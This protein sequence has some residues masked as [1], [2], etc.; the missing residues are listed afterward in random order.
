[1]PARPLEPLQVS[2]QSW[3]NFHADTT[4]ADEANDGE[5]DGLHDDVRTVVPEDSISCVDFSEHKGRHRKRRENG[6]ERQSGSGTGKE[7]ARSKTRSERSE[8]TVRPWKES[9][10]G[11]GLRK[12]F[13]LP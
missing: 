4:S 8:S 1:V 9:R 12:V 2:E 5:S 11:S 13:G 7:S 3:E 6:K 10:Q